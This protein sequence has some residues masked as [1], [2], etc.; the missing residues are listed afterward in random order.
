MKNLGNFTPLWNPQPG[1]NEESCSTIHSFKGLER[2]AVILTDLHQL[3]EEATQRRRLF[4]VANSQ[5]MWR[6]V[7]IGER[8]FGREEG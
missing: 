3:S 5:A 1:P 4:Y 2:P 7:G 6:L 8:R